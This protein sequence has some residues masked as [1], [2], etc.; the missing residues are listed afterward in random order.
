[1]INVDYHLPRFMELKNEL[2]YQG[3]GNIPIMVGG[4]PFVKKPGL[5][6][7]IGAL[8]SAVDACQAVK[9]ANDYFALQV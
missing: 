1:S 2:E 4:L 7:E 8:F 5:A 9:K 3:L 6:Q